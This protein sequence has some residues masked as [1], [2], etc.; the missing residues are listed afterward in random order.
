MSPPCSQPFLEVVQ[1]FQTSLETR[2]AFSSWATNSQYK[3]A[4]PPLSKS[5]FS[6]LLTSIPVSD[7]AGTRSTFKVLQRYTQLWIALPETIKAGHDENARPFVQDALSQVKRCIGNLPSLFLPDSDHPAIVDPTSQRSLSHRQLSSFIK[8][9]TLPVHCDTTS[10]KPVIV[11]AL[12]NGP[13]LGLACLATASYYTAAPMNIAG[14]ARQFRSD[15]EF[16]N[17]HAIVALESDIESLGLRQQWVAESG[18]RVLV[19]EKQQGGMTF[20]VQDHDMSRCPPNYR[21]TPNTA[22]D[23]S[24]LLF[25]SGTSGTK[26]VVPIDCFSLLTGVQCVIT[27]WGLGPDDTCLNM[28]PFY[29]IGGLV[30]NL[31]APVLSGGSTIL[32]AGFDPNVF[33]D[34]LD[35]GCGTWYYASPSM[36]MSILAEGN[37]RPDSLSRCHLRLVCNAAGGLLPA[38]AVRLRDTFRCNVLPSYGMTECMPISTPLLDYALDRPGTSGIGCGPEISILDDADNPLPAGH[39]GR[40]SV[41]GGPTFSGYLKGGKIDRSCFTHN[42][43]FDTGDLGSLDEDGYLYLTGRGKEI[44]NRGGEIISPF[45]VEEAITI[46]SQDV[47]SSLFQRVRQVMAFSVPHELL[48]EAVGVALVTSSTKPRPDIRELNA[49]LTPVLHASKLPL[50]IV[51]MEALPTSNNKIIRIKFAERLDL[52]PITGRE[53]LAQ[54]HFEAICPPQNSALSIKISKRPCV[55]DLSLVLRAVEKNLDDA[56]EAYVGPG[57]HDGT[58]EVIVAPRG[59]V[60]EEFSFQEVIESLSRSLKGELDG[61]LLPSKITYIDEIFPRN[62]SGIIDQLALKEILKASQNLNS[63]PPVSDTDRCIRLAFS[64]VLGIPLEEISSDSDFFAMGGDSLSAG[65]L[66]SILRRDMQV[67]IPVDQLFGTSRVCDLCEQVDRMLHANAKHAINGKKSLL[68]C[69]QTYSSTNPFVLFINILPIMLVYPMKMAFKWT[70]LLYALGTILKLWHD[71]NLAAKFVA[72]VGAMFIARSGTEIV[73]PIFGILFKWIVIGRY[74]EGIYPMWGPYHS[75]WWIVEKVLLVCGKGVFGYFD[76][77]RILYYRL[78]GAKIGTGV[79]I[80]K[81]TTLGEYDLLDIGDNVHLNRCVCRPFAAEQNTSMYLGKIIVGK[82]SSIGLKSQV[83]A[84]SILPDYTFIGANSSSYEMDDEDNSNLVGCPLKP[85]MLLRLFCIF[86][87]QI[88]VAFLSSLPWMGGLLGMVIGETQFD[89]D[90]VATAITWW[91]TPR[92]IAF[93]YLALSLNTSVRPFVWF[94]VIVLIKKV[95]NIFCGPARPLAVKYMAQKDNLRMHLLSALL[96]NGSLKSI[97]ELFGTHYEFTSIA[98]R[99]LGGKVGKHVYWPGTGPSIQDFDLIDIGDDVVFGSRSHIITT[100]AFGTEPVRIENG[101]MIADRVVVGPGATVGERSV[102]G[103]GALIKRNQYCAAESVWIGNK[104][105][106]AVCLT[107]SNF[108]SQAPTIRSSEDNEYSDTIPP[109]TE[110]SSSKFDSTAKIFDI[111][112]TTT[113][114]GRAFYE[115]KAPYYVF[116]QI[117]IFLYATFITIFTSLYWN[118]TTITTIVLSKFVS[119][120]DQLRPHWYRPLKIYALEVAMLSAMYTTL[121]ALALGIVVVAKWVLLGRRKPGRYDW[122]K[123]SYCQRWQLFLTIEAVRRKCFGGNGVL[124]MLTGTHFCVLYF[125]ALGANIGKDCALFAGGRPS[126]IF[127]EPD[128]LTLGDRVTTDDSSLVCHVN[129]RGRFSLNNLQVGNRSVLRSGS[130]LLSGAS[131][132]ED[133]TLLEHTLIMAGDSADDGVTYQGWPADIYQGSRLVICSKWA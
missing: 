35:G 1:N 7:D 4:A 112:S 76:Y 96:P 46:A 119:G 125:R 47:K 63:S 32:C 99:A 67:R 75:R 79:T 78:L 100:D 80:E 17:P 83:A 129:S 97:T 127:T 24:I 51:Y 11:L 33:W 23:I 77:T 62:P 92:R 59:R 74:R 65:Q 106:G 53:N 84:G 90:S 26:K 103:S 108:S 110:P 98:V 55:S 86:P 10:G 52:R 116:G 21:T 12:P 13:L 25:T 31:F 68:G 101:A 123:S 114:F 45:E 50:T 95:V 49:A 118:A 5:A 122:D 6:K 72:V 117:S 43:W 15:V 94:G 48:Q 3:L 113:P 132:G 8:D 102:I 54:R 81:G 30:R 38:L 120:T 16:A 64:K 29:H 85:H 128:L 130:R 61:Y 71:P 89:N 39:V 27:S 91:A 131:M 111:D 57:R 37:T 60:P 105:G 34:I 124:G 18:I 107:R 126:L 115:G 109:L 70:T 66:L 88:L 121:S 19:A 9:F 42:G 58:P 20:R 22:D 41:R 82:N 73:S 28:M 56:L 44:I 87:I 36:H 2:T 93:H 14:G 40:I 104:R 133:V 69:M